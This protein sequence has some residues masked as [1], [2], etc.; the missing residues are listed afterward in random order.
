MAETNFV[1]HIEHYALKDNQT[2]EAIEF[3]AP[4]TM[5]AALKRA[6]Y[7][8]LS[9][10]RF[11]IIEADWCELGGHEWR[12]VGALDRKPGGLRNVIEQCDRC[13]KYRSV[14]ASNVEW[15]EE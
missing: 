5:V 6:L 10:D 11:E 2:G 9:P 13:R 12:G 7:P 3:D 4:P 15:V 1:Q 14:A 8:N